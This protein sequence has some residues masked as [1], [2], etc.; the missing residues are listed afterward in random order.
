MQWVQ[1]RRL[2][3][4]HAAF[5]KLAPKQF[6]YRHLNQYLCVIGVQVPGSRGVKV[7]LFMLAS[8]T[9]HAGQDAV[10]DRVVAVE[11]CCFTCVV[12]C[13][14]STF[15]PQVPGLACPFVE[16]RKGKAGVGAGVFGINLQ[17][18]L[19]KLPRLL[20]S[21][22]GTPSQAIHAS[23]PAVVGSQTLGCL[24]ARLL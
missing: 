6:C 8:V 13:A 23:Q 2:A 16:V 10:R 18:A 11:F 9:R 12:K 4:E 20:V 21:F 5:F 1:L 14:R 7:G 19:E 17:C 24:S 22:Q 15:V 3:R